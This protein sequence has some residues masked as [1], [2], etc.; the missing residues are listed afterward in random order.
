MARTRR[1][2]QRRRRIRIDPNPN[3]MQ[4]LDLGPAPL[5]EESR[6]APSD[7]RD[8]RNGYLS[9]LRTYELSAA[10]ERERLK[11]VRVCGTQTPSESG[12]PKVKVR[13]LIT[14]QRAHR[15]R[16]PRK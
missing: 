10:R 15:K 6:E 7:F 11:G 3:L 5:S 4:A 12:G 14:K 2:R 13:K 9:S 16:A 8:P 1:Q